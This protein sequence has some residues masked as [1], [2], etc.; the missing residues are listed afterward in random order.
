[1][2]GEAELVAQ[3]I[4][5]RVTGAGRDA[6]PFYLIDTIE[7]GLPVASLDRLARTIAPGDAEFKHRFI[8]KATLARRRRDPSARLTADESNRL[9]RIAGVWT[10]AVQVWKDPE[11]ARGFLF[12][13]HPMLEGRRPIDMAFA[14][15]LGAGL[16]DRLLGGLEY[17]V[18]V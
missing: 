13:P 8:S 16:V 2:T 3:A 17:G 10:H 15:E 6:T 9:T 1:M 11:A 14:T 12:R 4:G 7:N 5:L 18:A